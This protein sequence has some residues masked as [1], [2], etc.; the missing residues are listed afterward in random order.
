MPTGDRANSRDLNSASVQPLAPQSR[1]ASQQPGG[2][3]SAALS[4]PHPYA[5]APSP[6]GYRVG[7]A[8]NS[9][10]RHSPNPTPQMLASGNGHMNGSESFLYGQTP[11]AKNGSGEAIANGTMQRD[12]NGQTRN[13]GYGE[14]EQ[15]QRVGEQDEDGGHGRPKGLFSWLCCRG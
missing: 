15:M 7:T 10:G 6:T 12:M 13:M 3:N 1:R 5:T 11:M 9:Y 2:G 8:N 4:A 14:R